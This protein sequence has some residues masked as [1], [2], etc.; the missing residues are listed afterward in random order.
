MSK[1]R[2][3]FAHVAG[4]AAFAGAIS[5]ASMG[6][7]QTDKKK[8]FS[9]SAATEQASGAASS[10]KTKR[11]TRKTVFRPKETIAPGKSVS[12]PPDI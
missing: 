2:I 12:F 6:F 4:A 3:S 11:Q 1:S 9:T 7:A 10:T 8:T 5:L